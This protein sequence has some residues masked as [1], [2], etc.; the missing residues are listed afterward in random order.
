[1]RTIKIEGYDL[2]IE[3]GLT[4]A[5]KPVPRQKG[6]IRLICEALKDG[7]SVV[8]PSTPEAVVRANLHSIGKAIGSKLAYRQE[9]NGIRIFRIAVAPSLKAVPTAKPAKAFG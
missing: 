7:E 6:A 3:T 5:P 8:I 9:G 4:P 2:K 1:M